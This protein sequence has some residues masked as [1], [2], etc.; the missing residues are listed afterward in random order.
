MTPQTKLW[1]GWVR[2]THWLIVLSVIAAYVTYEMERMDWHI[3]NGYLLLT[4]VLF[5]LGWGLAGS[6]SARFSQFLKGPSKVLAYLRGEG[7]KRWPGHNPLGGWSVA[8]LLVLLLT[9]AVLGLFST[10]DILTAGPLN[11][12]VSSSTGQEITEWH[13]RLY[14]YVLLPVIGVHIAAALFYWVA[15]GQNLITP[16]IT[17]Q[18]PVEG[19]GLTFGPGWLALMILAIAAAIVWAIATYG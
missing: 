9:Q 4:L 1:D 17:G 2:L 7:P 12:R 10:D 8:L 5:R 6:S 11:D 16:M 3:W 14:F 15:K 19:S 18:A 13:E